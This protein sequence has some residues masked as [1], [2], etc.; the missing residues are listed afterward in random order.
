MLSSGTAMFS[1]SLITAGDQKIT[2]V[3]GGDTNF[4]ASKSE[5][6]SQVVNGDPTTT[7]LMSSPNPSN[8][9]QSVTFTATVTPM[10]GGGPVP[11]NVT[12]MDG[13][14]K[15]KVVALSG[16]VATYTTTSLANG[17]HSITANYFSYNGNKN[18]AASSSAPLTQWVG[19]QP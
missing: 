11:G 7:M 10:Y 17:T 2:A 19:P 3:Y 9:G 14:T 5:A 1:T 6:L 12:F 15:L 16:G 8:S 18:Y 4:T 13:T